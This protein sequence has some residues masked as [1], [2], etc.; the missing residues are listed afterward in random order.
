MAPS[1]IH[2]PSLPF[3]LVKY[4]YKM[5]SLSGVLV[6]L[7][8][9]GS[10]PRYILGPEEPQLPPGVQ[11]EK[12]SFSSVRLI[13]Q[14]K[15]DGT[16]GEFWMLPT[17]LHKPARSDLSVYI[18]FLF[19]ETSPWNITSTF[20]SEDTTFEK[21]SGVRLLWVYSYPSTCQSVTFLGLPLSACTL[22]W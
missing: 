15:I 3:C 17:T 19:F 14:N 21:I 20:F 12:T 2:V 9:Q 13:R 11:A 1:Q 8:C 10:K 16:R 5:I 22:E 7:Y 18:S 4:L 6:R